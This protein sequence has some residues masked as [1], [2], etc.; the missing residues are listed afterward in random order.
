M[1]YKIFFFFLLDL[2]FCHQIYALS[3]TGPVHCQNLK[4]NAKCKKLQPHSYTVI[5]F[6]Q[7]RSVFT[8]ACL[9]KKQIPVALFL[10]DTCMGLQALLL[11]C[12][13]QYLAQYHPH[14]SSSLFFRK[15][16]LHL[17]PFQHAT[18][19]VLTVSYMTGAASYFKTHMH[20][21]CSYLLKRLT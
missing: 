20:Y 19:E 15:Q 17:L 18:T 1:D 4:E 11:E 5:Y 14:F 16:K 9:E 13:H 12:C 2:V 10:G 7:R 6:L 3:Q 21:I 8:G